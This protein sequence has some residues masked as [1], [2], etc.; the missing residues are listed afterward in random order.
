MSRAARLRRR[1][2]RQE[3][4]ALVAHKRLMSMRAELKLLSMEFTGLLTE[5]TGE[6]NV[7]Q[8]TN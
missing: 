6:T 2:T 1:I 5:L 3:R 7:D 4:R 8:E